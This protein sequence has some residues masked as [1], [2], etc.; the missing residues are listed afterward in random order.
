M[1]VDSNIIVYALNKRTEKYKKA[2]SFLRTNFQDLQIAQQNIL[3]TLRVMTHPK[4]PNPIIS[5]KL[6]GKIEKFVFN[7]NL[8]SPKVDT[9]FYT[10]GLIKKFKLKGNKIFDAYL[11]ATMLTNGVKKIATDNVSDFEKY[12]G[13]EVFNPF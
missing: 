7:L 10:L 5:R 11:V 2:R 9:L 12:K 3:E 13:I 4:Y 1:L 6:I 8:I